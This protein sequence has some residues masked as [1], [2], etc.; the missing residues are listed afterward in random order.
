M[1]WHEGLTC[2]IEA[3]FALLAVPTFA[4]LSLV[5]GATGQATARTA[6]SEVYDDHALYAEHRRQT[7]RESKARQAARDPE[8]MREK[9]RRA[10][11]R[12]REAR[13]GGA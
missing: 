1:S 10:K 5:R 9:W 6:S 4:G 3:M 7:F 12:Q 2:E 13:R 11:Q 8:A